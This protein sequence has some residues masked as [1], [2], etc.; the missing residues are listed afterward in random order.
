[1]SHSQLS[2]ALIPCY[3]LLEI[4]LGSNSTQKLAQELR[5]PLTFINGLSP[6]YLSNVGVSTVVC[7]KKQVE[8]KASQRKIDEIVFYV[9]DS[10]AFDY[11][12]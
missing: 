3:T 10:T 5:F 9:F 8:I 4:G 1:V 7:F 2:L 6:K 11:L 12:N